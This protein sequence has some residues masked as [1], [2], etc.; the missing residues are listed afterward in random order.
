MLDSSLSGYNRSFAESAAVI[1]I[2]W[3]RNN[4]KVTGIY[5]TEVFIQF[6][7]NVL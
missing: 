5:S 4:T 6:D 3:E 2:S 1:Y 7:S